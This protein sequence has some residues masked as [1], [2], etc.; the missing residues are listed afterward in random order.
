LAFRT[1]AKIAAKLNA[2]IRFS[3]ETAHEKAYGRLIRQLK[4]DVAKPPRISA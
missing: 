3:A 2:E 1:I 4:F